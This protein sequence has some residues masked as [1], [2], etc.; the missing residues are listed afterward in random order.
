MSLFLVACATPK[1]P[2]EIQ[3]IESQRLPLLI[4]DPHPLQVKSPQW[5]V[6][7]P[8]NIEKIWDEFENSSTPLVLFAITPRGYEELSL[9][10]AEIRAFIQTQR[11]IIIAYR[12]YYEE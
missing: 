10:L 8:E 2:I 3:K 12:K 5:I 4:N 1:K 9:S 6:V 11:E 7:T